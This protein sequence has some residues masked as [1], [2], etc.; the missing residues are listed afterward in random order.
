MG[1][2]LAGV[3]V[4]GCGSSSRSADGDSDVDTDADTDVD[5]DADTDVD[6][7]GACG[8]L[9]AEGSYTLSCPEGG[10]GGRSLAFA[11][12]DGE[13][14]ETDF[15]GG[16][17]P[18]VHV[19]CSIEGL[20]GGSLNAT[21]IVASKPLGDRNE[22]YGIEIVSAIVTG[23]AV[24]QYWIRAFD[25]DATTEDGFAVRSAKMQPDQESC[26]TFVVTMLD[27]CSFQLDFD[28]PDMRTIFD[29]PPRSTELATISFS[30]CD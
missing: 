17:W 16:D 18:E 22:R 27:E 1:W 25:Q 28:C 21:G 15:T 8:T 23:G 7:D 13:Q 20:E 10:C 11:G 3:V 14:N 4:A 9:H 29:Y 6:T 30:G 2:I 19:A 26:A 12:D 5:T 24:E